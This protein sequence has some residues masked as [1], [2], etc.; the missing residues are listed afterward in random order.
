MLLLKGVSYYDASPT[1]SLI[2]TN[3]HFSID[4]SFCITTPSQLGGVVVL[5]YRKILSGELSVGEF[6]MRTRLLRN[7]SNMLNRYIDSLSNKK[8]HQNC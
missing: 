8:T 6:S 3:S 7:V 4:E 1:I 2:S 5:Y